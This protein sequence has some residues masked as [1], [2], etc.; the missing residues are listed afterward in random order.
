VYGSTIRV[1]STLVRSRRRA[2]SPLGRWK[3]LPDSSISDDRH[4]TG[5]PPT[6]LEGTEEIPLL[7]PVCGLNCGLFLASHLFLLPVKLTNFFGR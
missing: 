5:E 1:L 4:G 6:I 3:D 7:Q 2:L